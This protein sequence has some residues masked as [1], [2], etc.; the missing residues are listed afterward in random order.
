MPGAYRRFEIREPKPRWISAAPFRDRV[1]HHALCNVIEPIFERCFIHHSYACRRGKGTHA[2]VAQCQRWARRRRFVLK[3]DLRKFFP[4]VDHALLK[5][6]VRRKIKDE[7]VLWLIDR[8]IDH[9]HDPAPLVDW[10]PGDDLLSP[11]DYPR[12]LP[13]GNQTSQFFANVMLNPFDHFVTERLRPDGYLR[14]VDDFV[15]FSDDKCWLT[16]A[17]DRCRDFLES[18]RLRL[19]PDKSVISPTSCGIRFLGYRVFPDRIRLPREHLVRW[20]RKLHQLQHGFS[21]GHVSAAVIGQRVASWNGHASQANS[22]R[23]R[24]DILDDTLFQR[25]P[26]V[27]SDARLSGT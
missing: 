18:L 5:S 19:H 1:V 16:D 20:R 15:L 3:C 12:G 6:I 7:K 11:L 8:I 22:W 13:I 21:E 10:F 2:A 17:R 23:L 14:Y 24:T 26:L 4:S 25:K 27:V 9:P